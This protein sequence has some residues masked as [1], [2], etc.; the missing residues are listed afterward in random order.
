MLV[1]GVLRLPFHA[2]VVV[3]TQRGMYA[4]LTQTQQSRQ[5]SPALSVLSEG[6]PDINGLSHVKLSTRTGGA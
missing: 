1:F 4:P 5:R 3:A 6:Y 2:N